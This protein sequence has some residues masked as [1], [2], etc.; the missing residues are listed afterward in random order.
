MK[1]V[2]LFLVLL[3]ASVGAQ[4]QSD[5]L[6][7]EKTD[8]SMLVLPCIYI[9]GQTE[10]ST[11]ITYNLVGNKSVTLS[12]SDIASQ[13]YSYPRVR[14]RFESFKFNNKFNDQLFTDAIGEIDEANHKVNAQV[15]CIGKRLTPS[16][17]VP[18]GVEV[19]ANGSLQQSKESRLR[20]EGPVKY[21]LA[22][23]NQTV[24]RVTP[25]AKTTETTWTQT[26]VDLTAD[27]LS[28]NAPSNFG[29]NPANLLDGDMST[30]FHSTWGTGS[31]KTLTWYSGATYGDGV[32]EWPYLQI[33]LPEPLYNLQFSYITRANNSDRAPLGLILQGS[34]DGNTWTDL[35]KFTQVDDAL[36]T[37]HGE[38]Y[39]S[40]VI[41]LSQSYSKLRLQL[42]AAQHKNYLVFSEFSLY[43]NTK[44]EIEAGTQY[45]IPIDLSQRTFGTTS[46]GWAY[47]QIPAPEEC[48]QV[49][50]QYTTHYLGDVDKDKSVTRADGDKLAEILLQKKGGFDHVADDVNRDGVVSLADITALNNIITKKSFTICAPKYFTLEGSTDG[51]NWKN[52]KFFSTALPTGVNQ[53]YTSDAINLDNTYKYLRFRQYR[54]NSSNEL[55]LCDLKL[56]TIAECESG[57]EPYGTDYSVEVDFLTDH[58]T[59][60]YNVPRIDIT[61]GDGQT[62]SWDQWID[63]KDYYVDATI[64]ID[65]AGVY[66]DMVET[67]VQIRGRGNTS[68]SGSPYEKNPYRLKFASKQKP[69]GLTKGK[70][71]V[72]LANKQAGS[73]TTN[74]LAMK[75]AGMVESRGANHIIPVELYIN[76]Q[77]RGSYNFTENPG[78]ANNSIELV[79]ETN[80]AML[81][82]DSYYDETYRFRDAAYN[83]PVNVKEPDFDDDINNG[84]LTKD[85]A[86]ARFSLIQQN[87]NAFTLDTK[88][89]GTAHLD[90][91][92][93]VRAMLV[94]DLVRN[95]EYKHPKSWK[96]YNPDISNPDSLWTFGPVWDFDWSYGYDG[97]SKYFIY[98]ADTD[99]FSISST[100]GTG[101]NFFKQL[102]RGS[103]TV[104]RAYYLL[105]KDFMESGKL[106]ELIEYCDDY[107]E[108]ANPSFQHNSTQW[109]DGNNY[110][111][112]TT[113]AKEWLRKRANYIYRNLTKYE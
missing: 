100:S 105:W 99:L 107:Y 4:A 83:L 43:E 32:S 102:L 26:K 68:W 17:K 77:Y 19:Y 64:Q 96:L 49:K 28:T 103:E 111:T 108:Y 31:Y 39:T 29:E 71:W 27:M 80:A 66:P 38:T 89:G 63:S 21:T 101:V 53:T 22:Y 3:F 56:Y 5:T 58:S 98:N 90:V 11:A 94:N 60:K 84:L 33:D 35:R 24:Y 23:P 109:S 20:F 48:S 65:G 87:F 46:D 6:F 45:A 30:I 73:M 47:Y 76:G 7:I 74:A 54:T 18:D 81:E 59:S 9:E 104:K 75:I 34:T 91:D 78:F 52:I 112:Q 8:G 40:P 50:F 25:K 55:L 110:S 97:P 15:S 67:A 13:R 92:A 106:D 16:F 44:Q 113:N 72:L 95:E 1:N 70:S 57:F 37:G 36:P 69:L 79:D 41:S 86:E 82:L 10:T 12:K 14:P 85:E 61:F 51:T 88:N 2:L 42:T 62:W 93:F